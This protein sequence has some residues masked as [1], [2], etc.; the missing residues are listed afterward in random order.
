MILLIEDDAFTAGLIIRLLAPTPVRWAR[1]GDEGI[2]LFRTM[3]FEMVVTD[4]VMPRR[5][6]IAT[7]I[8][9]RRIDG[10]IPILA[11]TMGGTEG[12]DGDLLRLAAS[13]GATATLAKP[14][15]REALMA[16]V[17]QCLALRA[18]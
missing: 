7:I 17:R 5:S 11:I 1:N 9:I 16:K 3:P 13:V 6:G 15:E 18:A 14:F 12:A 10:A 2:H 4:I 8:E